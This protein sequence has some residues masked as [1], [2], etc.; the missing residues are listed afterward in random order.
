[1]QVSLEDVR[2]YLGRSLSETETTRAESMVAAMAALLSARYGTRVGDYQMR[3]GSDLMPL[4]DSY[5]A[6]A[7][8]RKLGKRNQLADSENAGPFSVR[9]NAASSRGGWFL[10]E[11]LAELDGLLGMGGTRTY[12]TPAPDAQRFANL[13]EV[14]VPEEIELPWPGGHHV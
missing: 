13:L 1:M 4:I 2:P 12:R 14:S 5:V 3:T 8:E 7:V 9:W 6:A 10:S 11:E